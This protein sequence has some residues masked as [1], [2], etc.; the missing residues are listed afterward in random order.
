MP[1]TCLSLYLSLPLLPHLHLHRHLLPTYLPPAPTHPPGPATAH[2]AHQSVSKTTVEGNGDCLSREGVI[3]ATVLFLTAFLFFLAQ[4]RSQQRSEP[5]TNANVIRGGCRAAWC[6]KSSARPAAGISIIN[7]DD[8][9]LCTHC[10]LFRACDIH[11]HWKHIT[12][13]PQASLWRNFL[14]LSPPVLYSLLVKPWD[15]TLPFPPVGKPSLETGSQ[16]RN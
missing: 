14:S 3:N 10:A 7:S 6:C 13:T 5:I 1:E 12:N 4:A 11:S 9:L 16:R 2:E 15:L 8:S